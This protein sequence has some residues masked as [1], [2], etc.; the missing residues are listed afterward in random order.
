MK[1]N[2]INIIQFN[3]IYFIEDLLTIIYYLIEKK[4]NILYVYYK[5]CYIILVA[6]RYVVYS[7]RRII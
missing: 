2:N 1:D 4:N 3:Y 7:T 6:R 5:L